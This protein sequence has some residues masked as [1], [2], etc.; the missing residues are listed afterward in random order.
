MNEHRLGVDRPTKNKQKDR[1][2]MDKRLHN[3]HRYRQL[4]DFAAQ[5]L[6]CVVTA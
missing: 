3:A 4:W 1:Q 5:R 6:K 2:E